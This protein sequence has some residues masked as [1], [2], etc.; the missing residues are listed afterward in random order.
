MVVVR[1]DWSGVGVNAWHICYPTIMVP[2]LAVGG[3]GA[4][5]VLFDCRPLKEAEAAQVLALDG[6]LR[7]FRVLKV[8]RVCRVPLV[9]RVFRSRVSRVRMFRNTYIYIHIYTYIYIYI[10]CV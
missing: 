9:F 8:L 3:L 5:D 6:Q 7:V 10:K 1:W 4:L 2:Y